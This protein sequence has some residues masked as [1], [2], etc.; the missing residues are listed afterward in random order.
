MVLKVL[1]RGQKKDVL[2][3]QGEIFLLPGR[4]EHSPQRF[5]NTV[6]CVVER[7]RSDKE[8][9]CVRCVSYL[10]IRL[11][12]FVADSTERLYERWFHLEDVVK[13]LPPVIRDYKASQ[14]SRGSFE[15]S[16]EC[17]SGQPGNQSFLRDVPF[18]PRPST[19]ME[20][21]NLAAFLEKNQHLIG[22]GTGR[23]EE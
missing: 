1:E 18:E 9:D 7:T 20:P 5:T 3:R 19:L 23:G 12:Y 22:W 21:L 2:I 11:S 4:V 16:Q 13:D 10:Q 17:A 14:V 15:E 6:G 8:L